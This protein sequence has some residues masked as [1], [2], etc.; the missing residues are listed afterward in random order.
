MHESHRAAAGWPRRRNRSSALAGAVLVKR[1]VRR[2]GRRRMLKYTGTNRSGIAAGGALD[3]MSA[4][5]L[6]KLLY[7]RRWP[8]ATI[9][10]ASGETV[11]G[12]GPQYPGARQRIWWGDP[13]ADPQPRRCRQCGCTDLAACQTPAGPCAWRDIYDD[14]TGICT[15][16]VPASTA[17][18][19][20]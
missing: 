17:R 5:D 12:V 15:T 10:D 8:S 18:E 7:E 6:A 3:N 19:A 11:G 1:D 20:R 9:T 16:C 4:A 13:A 2:Q 14:N